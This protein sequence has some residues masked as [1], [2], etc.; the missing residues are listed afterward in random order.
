MSTR[1]FIK[2]YILFMISIFFSALGVAI[3][4]HANIGSMPVASVSN[5]LYCRFPSL[6]LGTWMIIWNIILI[7][8]QVIILRKDFK[9]YN[10]LQVP[11]AIAFGIFTDFGVW[12]ISG[13]KLDSY[14]SLIITVCIGI[15]VRSFG[16][17]LSVIADIILNSS[18]AFV[19]AISDAAKYKFGT[20]KVF[21]DIGCVILSV[22][23]SLLFFDFT[24]IGTR[25]A[26]VMSAILTGVFVNLFL[27]L[28]YKPITRLLSVKKHA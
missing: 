3:V 7:I 5:I 19:K 12:C 1:E 16:I 22:L 15:I 20:V 25:E 26:T 23:L 14:V 24:I 17:A 4:N 6:S 10:L 27:K 8:G 28:F 18:E 2:R 11:L 21:F 13:I 9:L